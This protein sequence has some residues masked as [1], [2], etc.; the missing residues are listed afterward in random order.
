LL[1]VPR[2]PICSNIDS[3]SHSGA[4]RSFHKAKQEE[5]NRRKERKT[6]AN[7][8]TKTGRKERKTEEEKASDSFRMG[9]GL[10]RQFTGPENMLLG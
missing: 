2:S 8:V 1:N 6:K 5:K 10:R 9:C 3:S 7:L 4:L